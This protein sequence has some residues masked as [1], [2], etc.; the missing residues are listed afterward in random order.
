[1]EVNA[2]FGAL[3]GAETN[4]EIQKIAR[5]VSPLLAAHGDN[6]RLNEE[7]F[8][9]VKTLYSQRD[10][11]KLS[12]EEKFLLENSYRDFVRGGALLD[13]K[14]KTRL[15][16]LNRDLAMLS[17]RFGDNLLAETNDFK[18]A[19]DNRDDLA[20]LPTSVVAM[21]EGNGP[22]AER[23]GKVGIHLACAQHHPL[24]HVLYET[25]VARETLPHLCHAWGPGERTR[26]QRHSQAD[27]Q[28]AL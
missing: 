16:E 27:R 10:Q 21:A 20:G 28:P 1:V 17:L 6:I 4:P 13:G 8:A 11:L 22:G 25:R 23:P 9:R 2:V 12:P 3:Q 18:L 5:E 24:P 7:L 19:L 26:Q 15:R 14:Q